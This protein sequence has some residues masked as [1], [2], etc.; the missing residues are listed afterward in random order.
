MGQR[1]FLRIYFDMLLLVAVVRIVHYRIP[2]LQLQALLTIL[3]AALPLALLADFVPRFVVDP[4][5]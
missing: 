3:G 5:P 4:I 2:F 1:P